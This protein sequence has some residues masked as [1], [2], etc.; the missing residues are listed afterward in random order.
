MSTL[1]GVFAAILAVFVIYTVLAPTLLNFPRFLGKKAVPCPHLGQDGEIHL[2]PFGA[3]LSA[4]YGKPK[5]K[6]SD[7]NLW[8]EK[9][10]CGSQCLEGQ[11]F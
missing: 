1:L 7:C 2:H 5:L 6:I 9:P 4:G 11:T 8:S 10:G 3:A